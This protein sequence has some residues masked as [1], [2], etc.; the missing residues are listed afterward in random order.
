MLSERWR[1]ADHQREQF[2]GPPARRGGQA[3]EDC[4]G[5]QNG[6]LEGPGRTRTGGARL[7]K[8]HSVVEI[9]AQHANVSYTCMIDLITRLFRRACN[10]G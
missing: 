8:L 10:Q 9:L 6:Q 4:R 5:M 2:A 1:A 7:W 3:A